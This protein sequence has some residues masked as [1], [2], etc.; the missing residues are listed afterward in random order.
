MYMF[1]LAACSMCLAKNIN[2]DEQMLKK[3]ISVLITKPQ[4]GKRNMQ[5]RK[6]TSRHTSRQRT[7]IKKRMSRRRRKL[8][9]SLREISGHW[10]GGA[11]NMHQNR[12]LVKLKLN[13]S[14]K[15]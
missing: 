2:I 4:R 5:R 8:L 6:L 7:K 3:N 13:C 14:F 15:F 9:M 1:C 11:T 12:I 10:Q